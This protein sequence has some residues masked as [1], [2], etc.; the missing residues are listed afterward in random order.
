MEAHNR[1]GTPIVGLARPCLYLKIGN[2]WAVIS[3]LIPGRTDNAIKNHWNST[4]KRKLK[5]KKEQEDGSY[6]GLTENL[7]GGTT[8]SPVRG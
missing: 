1:L 6:T 8:Y 2:R 3:K 4:I 5:M 7:Q